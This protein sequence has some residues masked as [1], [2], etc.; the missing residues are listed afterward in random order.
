[1]TY[2]DTKRKVLIFV[3]FLFYILAIWLFLYTK[4]KINLKNYSSICS[5]DFFNISLTWLSSNL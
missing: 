5:N 4:L 1:M 2:K 3:F